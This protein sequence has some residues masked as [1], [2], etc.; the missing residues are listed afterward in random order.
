MNAQTERICVWIAMAFPPVMV[1]GLLAAGWIPLPPPA[2][3]PAA[4]AAMYRDNAAG[5]KV[6]S[7]LMMLSGTL[8]LPLGAV[9][10][11]RIRKIEGPNSPLAWMQLAA[12]AVGAV[13]FMVPTYFWQAAAYRAPEHADKLLQ[14]LN[15]LAFL[16][17]LSAIFPAQLQ[18]LA[19]GLAI[20][21]DSNDPPELPRWTGYLSLWVM[22]LLLP[23]ALVLFF[24]TGP[25]AWNGILTIWLAAIVF[26]I[27]F[28]TMCAVLLKLGSSKSP[29]VQSS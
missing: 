7:L 24:F 6:C 2:A 15:D 27:W 11:A 23:S 22:V 25:F 28:Y 20:L 8:T 26:I 16:P 19:L 12:A 4:V 3:T 14:A 1:A 9:L 29:A 17:L 13:L 21:M 18:L 5:I 10:T